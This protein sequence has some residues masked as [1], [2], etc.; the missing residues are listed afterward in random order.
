VQYIPLFSYNNTI[1][2]IG[3][4]EDYEQKQHQTVSV[5]N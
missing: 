3:V 1:P 4:I 2:W 5:C